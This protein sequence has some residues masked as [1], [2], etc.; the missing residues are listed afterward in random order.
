VRGFAWQNAVLQKNDL[1]GVE[2]MKLGVKFLHSTTIEG[3]KYWFR[4]RFNAK[5]R[6]PKEYIP[7]CSVKT[8][9]PE[10]KTLADVL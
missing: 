7:D 4:I 5:R 6:Y 9:R 10:T 2:V 1:V 3:R 8:S